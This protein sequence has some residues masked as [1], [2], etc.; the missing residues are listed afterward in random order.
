[1]VG[2]S[3]LSIEYYLY[4]YVRNAYMQVNTSFYRPLTEALI[5]ALVGRFGLDILKNTKLIEPTS[6]P[7]QYVLCCEN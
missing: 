5:V 4:E 7:G 1:M 6:N 2:Q 3:G